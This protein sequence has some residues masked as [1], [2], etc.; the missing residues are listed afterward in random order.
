MS[1]I[2]GIV[3][4]TL[5]VIGSLLAISSLVASILFILG[6]NNIVDGVEER[7]TEPID[8]VDGRIADTAAALSGIGGGELNARLASIADQATSAED[9][10]EAITEHP[11][12]S[13]IPVDTAALED[14]LE[15][16]ADQAG[17]LLDAPVDEQPSDA[18]RERIGGLLDEVAEPLDG[19]EQVVQDAADSLRFWIRL[20]GLA[21]VLL[22]LWGLWAQLSLARGGRRAMAKKEAS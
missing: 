21:F 12:Y 6:A 18:D 19:V 17:Q 15:S 8:R 7:I 13:R 11:L 2:R 16:V 20:S 14:R 9:A 1:R 5:G 22:S 10:L 4:L 3:A